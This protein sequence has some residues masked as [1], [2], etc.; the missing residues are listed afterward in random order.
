MEGDASR[1]IFG[2]AM[3][4]LSSTIRLT[5][6]HTLVGTALQLIL[7]PSFVTADIFALVVPYLFSV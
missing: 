2:F 4:V 5:T 3:A 1:E 6:V 7:T